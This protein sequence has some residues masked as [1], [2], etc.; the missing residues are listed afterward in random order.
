MNC[1]L[2]NKIPASVLFFN[3]KFSMVNNYAWKYRL[4]KKSVQ[5]ENMHEN[6]A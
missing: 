1:L 4:D 3:A 5:V 6:T 2:Y